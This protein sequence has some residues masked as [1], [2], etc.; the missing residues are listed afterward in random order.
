MGAQPGSGQG[1]GKK[2]FYEK[3]S[4]IA[5]TLIFGNLKTQLKRTTRI[6]V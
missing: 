1:E 3:V 6:L 2:M 4:H 5:Q